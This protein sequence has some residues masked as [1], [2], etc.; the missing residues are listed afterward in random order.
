MLAL[1]LLLFLFC[2][3]NRVSRVVQAVHHDS[4]RRD[5]LERVHQREKRVRGFDPEGRG[6]VGG[7]GPGLYSARPR[8]KG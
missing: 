1:L 7:G 6:R 4:D 5:V 8:R 2:K 3:G